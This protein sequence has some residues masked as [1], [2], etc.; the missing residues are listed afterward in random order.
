MNLR[1]ITESRYASARKTPAHRLRLT[2]P[3]KKLRTGCRVLLTALALLPWSA[4]AAP[5]IPADD[6]VILEHLRAPGD[7]QTRELRQ[8]R[9]ALSWNPGDLPLAVQLVRRYLEI[10]RAEADPRYYGYAQAA[11]RPWWSLP[12]PPPAVLVLRAA[13]RQAQH[14]FDGAL[15]DLSHVLALQ[16]SNAQA[17]LSQ[18]IIL[19]VRGDYAGALRSCIPLLTVSTALTATA[20]ISSAASLSGQAEKSYTLLRQTLAKS[21]QATPQERLWALTLL[22]EIAAR[23]GHYQAAEQH[24]QQA[25]ALGLRNAYLLGA[26]AD[27]LLDQNRP[28][29]VKA[30]LQDDTRVDGLLLRLALAEQRLD[31]SLPKE[32]V[33]ALRMRFAANRLRG[34]TL[35]LRNEA[36]FTLHLLNQ[37]AEALRLARQNWTAQ[38]EPW[39]ARLLLEAA[40]RTGDHAAARPVLDWMTHTH[41]QDTQ[42]ERLA[43]QLKGP[44]P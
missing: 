28:V 31:S 16:P 34:D 6:A 38:R 4:P 37:S 24:F 36:R 22:A 10:G 9:A 43:A 11:L 42:L 20:C 40:L 39:D 35:H 29:E 15:E 13:L 21:P 3:A 33:E 41:L 18:A 23:M 17:W 7:P 12:Q 32:H 14:D 30:L 8:L 27:F 25:L 5:F 26:Y 2:A 1:P 44:P 19:E